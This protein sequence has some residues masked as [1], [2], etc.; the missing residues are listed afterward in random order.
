MEN[1]FKIR[2]SR[3]GLLVIIAFFLALVLVPSIVQQPQIF[4]SASS[5]VPTTDTIALTTNVCGWWWGCRTNNYDWYILNDSKTWS[6]PDPMVI[7][8]EMALESGFSTSA[9]AWNSYCGSYDEGLM[10]VNPTCN[11]LSPTELYY[12]WY[13]TYHASEIWS[14]VYHTLVKRWGSSCSLKNLVIG[15]LEWYN[16]GPGGA[17]SYCGSFPHGTTYAYKVLNDYYYP[18]CKDS[19]YKPKF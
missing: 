3:I 15:S 10:Q 6:L 12:A 7:K 18:F 14:N 1:Y 4:A 17:G 8:A 19:G 2:P 9:K 13:N 5:N 11:N 16:Q